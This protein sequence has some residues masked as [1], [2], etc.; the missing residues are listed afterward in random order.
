MT[1]TWSLLESDFRTIETIL[2]ELL[3]RTQAVAVHL[4]DRA[5][6]IVLSAGSEV[7]YDLH[8]FGSLA[9]A[10]L[11]ANDELIRLVGGARV[12][13]VACMGSFRSMASTIVA[14]RLVLCVVFDRRSSLGLVRHRMR[15]A[16]DRLTPIFAYVFNRLVTPEVVAPTAL[17]AADE[18]RSEAA[19]AID[20]L[21]GEEPLIED[22]LGDEERNDDPLSDDPRR[23]DAPESGLTGD[24]AR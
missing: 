17:A 18:F 13:G 10:D 15:R 19:S 5:G 23:E 11:S 9:A 1:S 6:Q 24:D 8:T 4:V 12:D 16:S 14:D 7:D 3:H 2:L 22:P 20:E 21:L